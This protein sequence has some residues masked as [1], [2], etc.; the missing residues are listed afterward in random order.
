MVY[1]TTNDPNYVVIYYGTI[2]KYSQDIIW[3]KNIFYFIKIYMV[4][5][6]RR[7]SGTKTLINILIFQSRI[8]Y[9]LA[10]CHQVKLRLKRLQLWSSI[11]LACRSWARLTKFDSPE[12]YVRL[13]SDA[14]NL[15]KYGDSLTPRAIFDDL[16]GA[17]SNCIEPISIHNYSFLGP[18][19]KSPEFLVTMIEAGMNVAR[20]NFS[21][22]THEY[23]A[24]T[25][26]NCR[27][28]AGRYREEKGFDP[29]LAIALDTKGPEIRTGLLEGVNIK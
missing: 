12:S 8:S 14:V 10:M 20:M 13:V 1:I 24:S 11:C 25:I 9:Q 21:H 29:S 2:H 17:H 7:K 28:A 19:S 3:N 26:A 5:R 23:H 4:T 16:A 18:V 15:L 22:G 27:E 6:I